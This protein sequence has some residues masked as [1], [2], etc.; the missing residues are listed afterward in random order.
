LKEIKKGSSQK[1]DAEKKLPIAGKFES[2]LDKRIGNLVSG[3]KKEQ[4]IRQISSL[5]VKAEMYKGP[6]PHPDHVGGYE[7]YCSGFLNRSLTMAEKANDSNIEN[8]RKIIEHQIEDARRGMR[9]GFAAFVVLVGASVICAVTG[10]EV[11]AG[12]F[13]GL[14][15][16]GV[17]GKFIL[18]RPL[19]QKRN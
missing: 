2:E 18:G 4:I 14:G 10:Q 13:L 15:I 11:I 3:S 12:G 5:L 19:K 17:I 6:F 16:V 7:R 1:K 8:N 9:Y